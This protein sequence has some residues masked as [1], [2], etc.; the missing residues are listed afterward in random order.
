MNA[1]LLETLVIGA[2]TYLFRAVSL[3][4]GSRIAWPIWTKKWLSFVTPAVLGAL[5]GPLLL[6]QGGQWA[7]IAHNATLIAT[8]P[9]AVVGWFT[10]SF[11]WTVAA[12]ILCFA[13]LSRVA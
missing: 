8:I 2:G 7:P 5:L 1:L 12:G 4:L 13:V 10:R 9:T 6:L 3:T 11:L